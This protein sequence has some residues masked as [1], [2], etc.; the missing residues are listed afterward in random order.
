[1]DA[2][3][4]LNKIPAIR[5]SLGELIDNAV[6]TAA[7][8]IEGRAK[9][10]APVDTGSLRNSIHTIT[11]QSSG[12]ADAVASSEAAHDEARANG[13]T[14]KGRSVSSDF[15]LFPDLP[16]PARS[17][18]TVAV[19]AEHGLAVERGTVRQAPQPY[20]TPA[21]EEVRPLF[22]QAVA[23]AAREAVR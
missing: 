6:R 12:Y 3:I 20:L 11:D 2:E 23:A 17:E 13:K 19:A 9:G 16:Q 21:V 4:T 15:N 10:Y 1:M 5:A 7:F 22:K 18:A 14:P 8:E